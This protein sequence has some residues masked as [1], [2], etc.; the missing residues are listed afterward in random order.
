MLPEYRSQG[1][2]EVGKEYKLTW[3][4]DDESPWQGPAMGT[5]FGRYVFLYSKF[6]KPNF[7]TASKQ[8]LSLWY[9]ETF[10]TNLPWW[11]ATRLCKRWHRA[12]GT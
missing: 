6:D 8:T 1:S 5:S 12:K 2:L 10:I 7:L 3:K 9:G 11:E 4:F